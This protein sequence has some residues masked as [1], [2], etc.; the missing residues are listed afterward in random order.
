MTTAL[1]V[2]NTNV[3]NE[4][5]EIGPIKDM[6]YNFERYNDIIFSGIKY[7]L[8]TETA[9][10]IK[11]LN[12][13][14]V[15][16]DNI[17]SV[18][19]P[20]RPTRSRDNLLGGSSHINNSSTI[21]KRNDETGYKTHKNDKND[22]NNMEDWNVSRN[23]KTTKIE[24]KTGIEKQINE[25]RV[26]LNKIS[27]KNFEVQKELIIK[28][29]LN[30]I[31]ELEKIEADEQ[32]EGGGEQTD[33]GKPI[34]ASTAG[35]SSVS[36][37]PAKSTIADL[38]KIVKSIFD[39][40][41]S[42]KFFSELYA[43][44]YKCL[45]DKFSVFN[46]IL[47]DFIGNFTKTIDD[48]NYIDPNENYD[49]FCD[50]TKSNDKRHALSSFILNLMKKKCVGVETVLPIVS[51]FLNV[52]IKYISEPNRTNEIEEI[53]ENIF[54]FVSQGH[55]VFRSSNPEY[56]NSEI[57]GLISNISAMK[58]KEHPSISNRI[59]FKYNDMVDAMKNGS[60]PLNK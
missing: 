41:S 59:I 29:V 36:S 49:G 20:V 34:E 1:S 28:E 52:S 56:W 42:N 21:F 14:F 45:V 19:T 16:T 33:D 17:V 25:I 47:T 4:N 30:F 60:T 40:A 53:A 9:D 57:M 2:E 38:S 18:S 58:L 3:L 7:N 37:S 24:A 50:Y 55:A 27:N 44:L 13:Q 31:N 6:Y 48:I 32:T 39:I 26:L 11:F 51:H 43:E 23:F 10:V 46:D 22:I 54:I 12:S 35:S 15:N 5:N 8:S